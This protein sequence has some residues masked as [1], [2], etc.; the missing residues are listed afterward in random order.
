MENL[1]TL[2]ALARNGAFGFS[3]RALEDYLE[4]YLPAGCPPVSHSEAYR[5][6]YAPA[7]RVVRRDCLSHA[8]AGEGLGILREV[9]GGRLAQGGRT[10]VAIDGRCASGKTTLAAA[11]AAE[12]GGAVIHMDDFFLRPEQ[13]TAAR[14]QEPGG[15]VDRERFLEEVLLP[16]RRGERVAYRPFDCGTQ[17]LA[18]PRVVEDRPLVVVEGS[19][20]CHPELADH[21]D[22]RVFLTV[23]PEEQMARI[24]AREGTAYARTF[25]EKWIP[26]EER[27]FSHLHPE[28]RCELCLW[29]T[30]KTP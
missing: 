18:P 23:G 2:K 22:L 7:Y 6:A 29:Q 14:Y 26:L 1:E 5:E 11:L 9:L 25:R 12:H 17:R 30:E 4:G 3:V 8:P 27:Y 21:Y 19:Y 15:N 28:R 20:S 24:V 16:L 10:V 13:R